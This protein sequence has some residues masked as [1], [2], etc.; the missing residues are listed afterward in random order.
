MAKSS[1][2][3]STLCGSGSSSASRKWERMLKSAHTREHILQCIATF[4]EAGA[5]ALDYSQLSKNKN[6]ETTNIAITSG[7]SPPPS[8]DMYLT[9]KRTSPSSDDHGQQQQAK[10]QKAS[11]STRLE[12]GNLNAHDL[13]LLVERYQKDMMLRMALENSARQ[14]SSSTKPQVM[15]NGA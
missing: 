11:Q 8:D 10:V 2:S 1:F 15:K 9:T 14:Q 4:N 7:V 5:T 12:R 3:Q 6:S 13:K